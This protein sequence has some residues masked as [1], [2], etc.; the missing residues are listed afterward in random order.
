[1]YMKE[2]NTVSKNVRHNS[3]AH[4]RKNINIRITSVLIS[5]WSD[6][7]K[8]NAG[9]PLKR[10]QAITQVTYCTINSWDSSSIQQIWR[11]SKVIFAIRAQNHY[12]TLLLYKNSIRKNNNQYKHTQISPHFTLPYHIFLPQDPFLWG[13]RNTWDA[14]HVHWPGQQ[15]VSMIQWTNQ[16]AW[17]TCSHEIRQK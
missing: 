11:M 17:H 5:A 9:W 14:S 10:H 7:K 4:E 15:D 1:M 3:V 2:D 16:S 6:Y 8:K 12:Q 13:S